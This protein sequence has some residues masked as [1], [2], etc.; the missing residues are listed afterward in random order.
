MQNE[1][2]RSVVKLFIEWFNRVMNGMVSSRKGS[3]DLIEPSPL[4]KVYLNSPDSLKEPLNSKEVE[5][6]TELFKVVIINYLMRVEKLNTECIPIRNN[7]TILETWFF[8]YD[9]KIVFS[10]DFTRFMFV[11]LSGYYETEDNIQKP[12]IKVS[13]Y[14]WEEFLLIV[15]NNYYDIFNK[16]IIVKNTIL[17]KLFRLKLPEKEHELKNIVRN[18]VRNDRVIPLFMLKR[19]FAIFMNRKIKRIFIETT[20]DKVNDKIVKELNSLRIL[21]VLLF[22][23]FEKAKKYEMLSFFVIFYQLF[24]EFIFESIKLNFL[25]VNLRE[26]IRKGVINLFIPLQKLLDIKIN[27]IIDENKESKKFL[28]EYIK[29]VRQELI[30]KLNRMIEMGLM[31]NTDMTEKI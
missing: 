10:P 15:L 17:G 11:Y 6:M 4:I 23:E 29:P 31:N 18:I 26:I 28:L 3:I 19:S 21:L 20:V 27:P 8:E 1:L 13:D 30:D 14:V 25:E 2:I 9:K 22:D 16:D 12:I 24:D 5:K 7:K